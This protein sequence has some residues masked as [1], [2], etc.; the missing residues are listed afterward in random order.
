MAR[1]TKISAS[2]Q[3]EY[4]LEHGASCGLHQ[5]GE[6][7]RI[8]LSLAPA[9][10]ADLVEITAQSEYRL[11]DDLPLTWGQC[12]A[13]RQ[14]GI[15]PGAALSE[16]DKDAARALMRGAHPVTGE[17]LVPPVLRV[18]PAGTLSGVM[19]LSAIDKAAAEAGVT[20]EELVAEYDGAAVEYG[21]L[22]KMVSRRGEGHRLGYDR[23]ADLAFAAGLDLG[24]VYGADVA[25]AARAN[26]NRRIDIRT[27]G[28]DLTLTANKSF[29]VLYAAADR[30]GRRVLDELY[31]SAVGEV[32]AAMDADLAYGLAGHRG[33]GERARRVGT[34]GLI[35]WRMDHRVA[36]P[37]E[38]QV[39]DPHQHAHIVIAAIAECED[40]TW[41]AVANGG[42]DLYRHAVA[43]NEMVDHLYRSKLA[44]LG[45]RYVENE[46]T[47]QWELEG[48][49]PDLRT[50]FSKRSNQVAEELR[51]L[52]IDPASAT[53]A[54]ARLA[55]SRSRQSK[56]SAPAD[57]DLD[58]AW[59]AQLEDEGVDP[60]DLVAAVVPG[61]G[62]DLPGHSP[63]G[64]GGGP[65]PVLPTLEQLAETVFDPATGLT[66]H[67][68]A[69]SRVDVLAA[70]A[71]AFPCGADLPQLG[72][73]TDRLLASPHAVML[74]RV[75]NPH[76]SNAE[77][78]TTPDII[79]AEKA[80]LGSTRDRYAER[81]GVLSAA[82]AETAIGV[83]EASRGYLLTGEQ[84]AVIRRVTCEGIGVDAVIGAAGAGKTVLTE[85]IRVA[86][87][88]R[89]LVV[90]GATLAATAGAGLQLES[91]IP[92]RTIASWLKRIDEAAGLRGIDVL[93]VDEAAMTDDRQLA[94]LLAEAAATG[95]K[96]LLIGD[97]HQLK[98]PGVGGAFNAV[99]ELV[100]G[101]TLN[102]NRRQRDAAERA[103]LARWRRGQRRETLRE[104]AAMGRVHATE[105]AA[106][107]FAQ[108][109]T[110][111][112]EASAAWPDVHERISQLLVLAA[113]NEAADRINTG[114]RA[115]LRSEGRLP[116]D[117]HAYALKGG[118]ELRIAVGDQ[119]ML[120]RNDYRSRLD[121]SA[122]DVLNGYR[123]VVLAVND[124][125]HVLVEWRS[126]DGR[127]LVRDWVTP[128]YIAEG[129]LS[130]AYAITVAKSQGMT[131]EQAIVY[132]VGLDANT[133]Y[134]ALTRSRGRTDLILPRTLLEAPERQRELGQPATPGEAL[135][136][137]VAALADQVQ[138]D[139]PQDVVLRELGQLLEP[140]AANPPATAATATGTPAMTAAAANPAADRAAMAANDV[141]EDSPAAIAAI[142]AGR[143][144]AEDQDAIED[145][146]DEPA[147]LVPGTAEYI[148]AREGRIPLVES[149]WR[150]RSRGHLTA[151]QLENAIAAAAETLR[152]AERQDAA[153]RS[154][155]EAVREGNGPAVTKLRDVEAPRIRTQAAAIKA[156]REA[157]EAALRAESDVTRYGSVIEGLQSQRSELGD[158]KFRKRSEKT[159]LDSEITLFEGLR[160]AAGETA[161]EQRALEAERL[162]AVDVP[163]YSENMVDQWRPTLATAHAHAVNW[164]WH[165]QKAEDADHRDASRAAVRLR[166]GAVDQARAELGALQAEAEIRQGQ[167][168]HVRVADE[169]ARHLAAAEARQQQRQQTAAR[170]TSPTTYQNPALHPRRPG[171]TQR[172]PG[173]SLGR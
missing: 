84:R 164:P 11:G 85:A 30:S 149:N 161:A 104:L 15:T 126:A 165:L 142:A 114:V 20:P 108:I 138:G 118:G 109:L 156:V 124:H 19:L 91:G 39:P 44:E 21:R 33:E 155:I 49:G 52:G 171:P 26:R 99:H 17:A 123:G 43:I 60:A 110:R 111:Y 69:V 100:G 6:R 24:Q 82:E 102:D 35:W 12:E 63:S 92:T 135:A 98:S 145:D 73:L 95:T 103:A 116:E 139:R 32:M 113:T 54:E 57:V 125:R 66:A 29:S 162:E 76:L 90:A 13:L 34:S 56:T 136:R 144:L 112:A 41:R 68:K 14:F 22:A 55:T 89:G 167:P 38:G 87:E 83:V 28:Y 64:P 94:R 78:Y 81:A 2:G 59:H 128:G 75:Q 61:L 163:E 143:T 5:G 169:A 40:G 96:V 86:Y 58:A 67:R 71:A 50:L 168:E 4:R 101:L 172:P 131:C 47:G 72:E 77:R 122:P 170:R 120:R 42:I 154:L 48:I 119:V 158:G 173:P 53:P 130:L 97:P 62:P 79:R 51:E 159:K 115:L 127:G 152:K 150:E 153:D 93:V 151:T 107:A 134:P 121:P 132:G 46:A 133:L 157:R 31:N 18:D 146:V 117:E 106:E 8:S 70:V 36:R 16:A 166:S 27:Q 137:A 160:T 7:E 10:G 140:I 129:G 74:P 80:I 45:A 37:V 3:V 105:T 9:S 141:D 25:A 88:A 1:V 148:R 147:P 65:A 23:V